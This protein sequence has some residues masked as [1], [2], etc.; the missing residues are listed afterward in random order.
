MQHNVRQ[1][2]LPPYP[3]FITTHNQPHPKLHQDTSTPSHPQV[4]QSVHHPPQTILREPPTKIELIQHQIEMLRGCLT[5]YLETQEAHYI[6]PISCLR[7]KWWINGSPNIDCHRHSNI[8][9]PTKHTIP[10]PTLHTDPTKDL[11]ADAKEDA[12]EDGV[13]VAEEVVEDRT[14]V[15]EE[16]QYFKK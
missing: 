11:V 5:Q 4:C 3:P 13:A 15:A 14:E 16:G 1:V 9:L 2:E 7:S 12:K 10:T 6:T 8:T